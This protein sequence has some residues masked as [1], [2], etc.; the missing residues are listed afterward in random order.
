MR[1]TLARARRH[2]CKNEGRDQSGMTDSRR[3]RRFARSAHTQPAPREQSLQPSWAE[4]SS[5]SLVDFCDPTL[6]ATTPPQES[7]VLLSSFSACQLFSD[8]M[9]APLCQ[10]A[11]KQQV[12]GSHASPVLFKTCMWNT[13]T[14]RGGV[15][16]PAPQPQSAKHGFVQSRAA[17]S[18]FLPASLAGVI[19]YCNIIIIIAYS[20]K[21]HMHCHHRH[22]HDNTGFR[23][24][25]EGLWD[26]DWPEALIAFPLLFDFCLCFLTGLS[27]SSLIFLLC[28]PSGCSL[29]W[30]RPATKTEKDVQ[31][32]L[33]LLTLLF[34]QECILTAGAWQWEP[35]GQRHTFPAEMLDKSE[36]ECWN[37]NLRPLTWVQTWRSHPL[38]SP[39][40]KRLL[41]VLLSQFLPV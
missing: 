30:V 17:V 41:Y 23:K 21:K 2:S 32:I 36:E 16:Q 18:V 15:P 7:W 9:S 1:R 34:S 12:L 25:L 13:P 19:D 38:L 33:F 5:F 3:Q 40:L 20:E 29:R 8:S 28:R 37:S 14:Q 10:V 11:P 39:P 31:N 35:K 4:V 22:H 27:S 26:A 24:S 6:S